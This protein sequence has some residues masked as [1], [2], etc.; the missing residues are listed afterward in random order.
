MVGT[1]YAVRAR[2]RYHLR[3]IFCVR[4]AG[5]FARWAWVP[6][7][8]VIHLAGELP[9]D[10][11]AKVDLPRRQGV[12][13]GRCRPGRSTFNQGASHSVVARALDFVFQYLSGLGVDA[14]FMRNR[15][16]LDIEGIAQAATAP[17][18]LQFFVY[19]LAGI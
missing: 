7:R 2:G 5:G 11:V 8:M 18:P 3:S 6:G 9:I 10:A 4:S 17:F 14:D 12:R 13:P 15:T 1:I 16:I 19:D